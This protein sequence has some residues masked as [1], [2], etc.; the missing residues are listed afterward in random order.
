MT[1]VT[2]KLPELLLQGVDRY[3]KDR[4]ETKTRSQAVR[5]ILA[6]YLGRHG[7]LAK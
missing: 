5:R 3:I 2:M 4:P 7:Y 1:H 6:D